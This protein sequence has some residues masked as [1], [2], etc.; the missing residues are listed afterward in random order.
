MFAGMVCAG[1][2]SGGREACGNQNPVRER[3]MTDVGGWRG[4]PN[5]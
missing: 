5:G 2:R 3:G 1:E 4:H